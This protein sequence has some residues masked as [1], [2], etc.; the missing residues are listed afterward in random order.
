MS[1]F[2]QFLKNFFSAPIDGK[3]RKSILD[4]IRNGSGPCFFKVSILHQLMQNK[5]S[6][7]HA[8]PGKTKFL[9]L[10]FLQIINLSFIIQIKDTKTKINVLIT[11]TIQTR[12]YNIENSSAQTSD[13]FSLRQIT[14][15]ERGLMF[16][17]MNVF[18]A[19]KPLQFFVSATYKIKIKTIENQ[20]FF[21]IF[22]YNLITNQTLPDAFSY[23]NLKMRLV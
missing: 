22:L 9:C 21:P 12:L 11:G 23:E 1:L 8:V 13:L 10:K 17:G 5:I 18:E 14:D 6:N 19:P 7:T 3:G 16:R 15:L 4:I 20:T 2:D